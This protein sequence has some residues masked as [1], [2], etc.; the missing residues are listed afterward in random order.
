MPTSITKTDVTRKQL[1]AAVKSRIFPALIQAGF[2]AV[3]NEKGNILIYYWHRKRTD[4][5]YDLLDL[6]FESHRRPKF[7]A[8]IN[9]VGCEG[10]VSYNGEHLTA[11]LVRASHFLKRVFIQKV[12]RSLWGKI[13][14]KWFRYVSFGV[15]SKSKADA[16]EV[17][18]QEFVEC[19]NQAEQWWKNRKL[20]PNIFE[21]ELVIPPLSTKTTSAK[22]PPQQYTNHE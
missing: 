22:L 17:I 10:F 20:G 14:P 6:I 4:N 18:C 12:N 9:A 2:E 15:D 3:P 1:V 11:D 7:Y 8:M 16:V 13:L 5:G 19:L 21:A